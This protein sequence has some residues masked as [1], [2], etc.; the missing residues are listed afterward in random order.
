MRRIGVFAALIGLAVQRSSFVFISTLVVS[1]LVAA[2]PASAA[3]L[4]V[5]CPGGGPGAYPSI[6]AA[7]NA[8]TNNEGPNS[9]AVS[10]T[11]TENVFIFN[12][13][14][15]YIYNAPG[16]TAVITNAANPAQ[17][18][19]QLFGSRLV[20]FNGLSIQGGN[21]G[22]FVNQGSDLQMFNSVIEKNVGDGALALI[23][24]DLNFGD[25]CIIRN[26]GG[27]GLVVGDSSLVVVMS[28]IQILNN[29]GPG[30]NV[31]S[32][33]YVK[34][35][36]TGGHTI[37]GN[38]GTAILA[39]VDGH[40][41]LQSIAHPTVIS[42]NGGDGL[43]FLQG[44]TGRVDGQN[45]IENNG[46]LGVR[47]DSSTVTFFGDSNGSTTIAGHRFGVGVSS[48]GE[49]TFD[50]PHQITGNG[51]LTNEGGIHVERSSLSLQNGATVSSN[52]GIG[53]L[54]DAHS[55]VVLGPSAS[56]TGNSSGGIRLRHQSL[57]GLTGPVT[58][59]GNGSANIVCDGSSLAYGQ[60][61]GLTGV[62]CGE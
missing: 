27:N 22:L 56:V 1:V 50:G 59:Q 8:I 6:T 4:T 7:L 23:K 15:L 26:N 53:I 20:T 5:I 29:N 54:G 24:S 61:A 21:P 30:V 46:A 52:T 43:A 36:F 12:Q 18:T 39:N 33:G 35:Q 14:N 57:V 9:I 49:L 28:P 51:T 60:L 58:I 13:K 37:E 10:G 45:T 47:V 41:F 2:G 17:I 48:G 31:F 62:Q 44:S 34:F 16:T 55:G 32:S 3:D 25:S 42:N 40:V 19:V 38:G 11:C